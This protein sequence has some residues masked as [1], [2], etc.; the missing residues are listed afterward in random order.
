MQATCGD[1]PAW[2]KAENRV[3]ESAGFQE[4]GPTFCSNDYEY[5]NAAAASTLWFHDHSVGQ[6]RLN[7][8]AGLAGALWSTI[9]RP[10]LTIQLLLLG[11]RARGPGRK[12]VASLHTRKRQSLFLSSLLLYGFIHDEG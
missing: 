9:T 8:F 12:L 6:T 11:P 3:C 4:S 2:V 5:P 1:V 7:I 10:T